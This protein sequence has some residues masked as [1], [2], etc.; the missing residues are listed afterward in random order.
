MWLIWR[1]GPL[2][3]L[4]KRIFVWCM[5]VPV[6]AHA[7]GSQK[8]MLGVFFVLHFSI[9][10]TCS[11]VFVVYEHVSKQGPEQDARHPPPSLAV[12]HS[13]QTG[14]L[15]EHGVSLLS[16]K[17]QGSSCFNPHNPGVPGTQT[18]PCLTFFPSY[19]KEFCFGVCVGGAEDTLY[20]IPWSRGCSQL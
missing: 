5:C 2:S 13:F 4:A 18:R 12:H 10:H 1:Q 16:S 8:P 6:C 11:W 9:A 15:I 17:A 7:C 20:Q 14:S 19:L 3:Y